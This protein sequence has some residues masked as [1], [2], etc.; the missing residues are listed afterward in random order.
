[1]IRLPKPGTLQLRA[2]P[3]P[4]WGEGEAVVGQRARDGG[5]GQPLA[6]L[7]AHAQAELVGVRHLQVVVQQVHFQAGIAGRTDQALQVADAVEQ[8]RIPVIAGGVA[9]E[10]LAGGRVAEV[11]GRLRQRQL[12]GF[13]LQTISPGSAS[14]HP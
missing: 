12:G 1:M 4:A 11:D 5:V 3:R 13:Q 6:D 7:V 14:K 2:W 9:L 8:V 10:A